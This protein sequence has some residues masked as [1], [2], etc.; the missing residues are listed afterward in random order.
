MPLTDNVEDVSYA[1][2][3]NTDKIFN[4]S[5]ISGSFTVNGTSSDATPKITT[6]SL[7]NAVGEDV[8][9][10]MIFSDNNS[11]WYDAGEVI[12]ETVTFGI[13]VAYRAAS[14]YTTSSNIV[15]AGINY[16]TSS[17]TLYYKIVLFAEN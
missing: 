9:P 8:L 1:S 17:F 4:E 2:T 10:V 6:S 12:T 3:L 16:D 7:T 14:C 11:D 15:V 13:P 5:K